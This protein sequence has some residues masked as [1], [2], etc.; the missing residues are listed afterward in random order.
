MFVRVV[1]VHQG[2]WARS[3]AVYCGRTLLS[4]QVLWSLW[5]LWGGGGEAPALWTHTDSAVQED[6][7]RLYPALS[8][9]TGVWSPVSA[10][11]QGELWQLPCA[12]EYDVHIWDK[13]SLK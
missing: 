7:S 5:T 13:F 3:A 9:D 2:M 12:C 8:Q 4:T 11:L 1:R 6:R 10:N